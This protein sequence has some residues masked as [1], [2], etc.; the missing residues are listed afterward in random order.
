MLFANHP[1]RRKRD[2]DPPDLRVMRF[3]NEIF[4]TWTR[5]RDFA[6]DSFERIFHIDIFFLFYSLNAI[7]VLFLR[8]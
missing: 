8:L 7:N 1:S 3:E 5:D 6:S 2:T 4:V